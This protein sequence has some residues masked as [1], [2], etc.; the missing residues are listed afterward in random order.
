MQMDEAEINRLT[1]VVIGCAFKVHNALGSGFAERV[2]ANALAHEL[3]KAGVQVRIEM[4]IVVHY[5]GVVVGEYF[6]DL[7]VE[8]IVLVEIK[9]VRTFNDGH[10]AQCLNYLAA[11]ALPICLLLNFGGRVEV[12]RIRGKNPEVLPQIKKADGHR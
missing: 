6:A 3:Q 2:Y 12:R 10:L 11:T 5:D 4:P 9:A 8:S 7:V 1:E